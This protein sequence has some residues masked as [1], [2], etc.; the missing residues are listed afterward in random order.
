MFCWHVED[1]NMASINFNHHGEAKFW[2]GIAR[3]DYKK[4]EN[5][6]KNRYPEFFVECGEFLRHKTLLINPYVLKQWMPDIQIIKF[7]KKTHPKERRIHNNSIQCLSLW[8]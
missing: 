3:T 7:F 4:F 2:Y 1:L 8:L 6:V 5:F